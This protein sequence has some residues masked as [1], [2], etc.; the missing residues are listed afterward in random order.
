V[1]SG[2]LAVRRVRR[3]RDEVEALAVALL[4]RRLEAGE[5]SQRLAQAAEQ[6]AS[7]ELDPHTAAARL[8]DGA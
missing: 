4:R 1:A 3:A 7:G 5:G 8:V 6:V 2:E